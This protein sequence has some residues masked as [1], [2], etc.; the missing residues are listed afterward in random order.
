MRAGGQDKTPN[1]LLGAGLHTGCEMN[2]KQCHRQNSWPLE[3]LSLPP[4]QDVANTQALPWKT[5][6]N[7][8]RGVYVLHRLKISLSRH[9]FSGGN[10]VT[11][12]KAIVFFFFFNPFDPLILSSW[13]P[14]SAFFLSAYNSL[15]SVTSFP[16]FILGLKPNRV[17]D[18]KR[19][20][21]LLVQGLLYFLFSTVS[22]A[23]SSSPPSPPSSFFGLSVAKTLLWRVGVK[24]LPFYRVQAEGIC[25]P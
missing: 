25:S 21:L 22:P 18:L 24:L 15:S 9:Y 10:N 11:N 23:S 3:L 20:K 19:R 17:L 14:P 6:I 5:K 7:Q 16:F 2:S 8:K 13:L 4:S 12:T 1:N